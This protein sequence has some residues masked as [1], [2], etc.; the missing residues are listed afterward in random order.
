MRPLT[1][2]KFNGDTV[3]RLFSPEVSDSRIFLRS[4]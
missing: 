3:G 1:N 2:N 4:D